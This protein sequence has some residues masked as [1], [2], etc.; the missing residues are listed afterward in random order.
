[1]CPTH[2]VYF[3]NVVQLSS[4]NPGEL[5]LMRYVVTVSVLMQT[6]VMLLLMSK[7]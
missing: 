1:M 3:S 2:L 4:Y 5:Y 7:P 6:L